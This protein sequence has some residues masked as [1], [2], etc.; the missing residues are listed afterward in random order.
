MATT[1]MA[2]TTDPFAYKCIVITKLAAKNQEGHTF[3]HSTPSQIR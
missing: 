3:I 1:N 2:T